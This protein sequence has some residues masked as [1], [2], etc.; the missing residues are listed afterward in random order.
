[1]IERLRAANRR[2]GVISRGAAHHS[3][4]GPKTDAMRSFSGLVVLELWAAR[5]RAGPIGEILPPCQP[6]GAF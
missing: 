3:Q 5:V 2:S 1:M 6:G 4:G